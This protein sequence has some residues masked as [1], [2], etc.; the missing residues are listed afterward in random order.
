MNKE[1]E[2]F[3]RITDYQQAFGTPDGKRVLAHMKKLAQYNTTIS[4]PLGDDGHT[5]VYR[6]M[7]KQGQRCVITNIEMMLNKDPSEKKGI[8]NA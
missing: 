8:K 1:D 5:D 7:Y 2:K 4:P 3:Q 6:V